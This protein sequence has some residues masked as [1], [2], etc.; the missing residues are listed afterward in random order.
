TAAAVDYYSERFD[1]LGWREHTIYP[2]I[3]AL[4]TRLRDAGHRLLVVTSKPRRHAAPIVAQLPFGAAF[5]RLY[6]PHPDS[7]HSDKANLI[8]DALRDF[9]CPAAQAVMIGDR[10]FDIDGALANQVR[11]M[12][13]LWGF[14]SRDE[15][16]QAGA[17]AVAATPSELGRLLLD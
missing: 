5:E 3:E 8:A 7:A 13:V 1:A 6:C 15:L 16:V 17:S 4:I 12:G 9:A 14:G 11:G 10:H 2:G